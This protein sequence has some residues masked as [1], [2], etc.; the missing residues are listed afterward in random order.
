MHRRSIAKLI[1]GVIAGLLALSGASLALAGPAMA[2]PIT[3][4]DNGNGTVTVTYAVD[5]NA[6]PAL[7]FCAPGSASTCSPVTAA[8]YAV[9]NCAP[10][11][12]PSP[13]T[14]AEGSPLVTGNCDASTLAAGTYLV[15]FWIG[16]ILAS[17]DDVC[18]GSDCPAP[19]VPQPPI[20]AW[21][22]GYGRASSS[23]ECEAG[24]SPSWEQ[25]M[26]AGVGGWVC[27]RSIPSLG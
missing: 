7:L 20:P 4:T 27:T 10:V 19:P 9:T 13:A 11:L 1:A 14:Y 23:E 8:F 22:Q 6:Y 2:E 26:N 21:V 15:A 17:A 16:G 12:E 3:I 25:W 18:I 24:W 5:E